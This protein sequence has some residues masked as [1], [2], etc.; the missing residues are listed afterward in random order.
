[1][2]GGGYEGI[3]AGGKRRRR[4]TGTEEEDKKTAGASSPPPA[5]PHF[6]CRLTYAAGRGG[7]S[8]RD[9]AGRMEGLVGRRGEREGFKGVGIGGSYLY[10]C[11][12]PN[13][14]EFVPS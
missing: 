1:M 4:Q 12:R 2:E 13:K 9:A 8:R 6:S 11:A 7:G 14:V 5:S 3:G 10:S